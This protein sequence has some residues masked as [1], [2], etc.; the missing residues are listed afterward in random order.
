M[1]I[2]KNIFKKKECVVEKKDTF[3]EEYRKYMT[4]ISMMENKKTVYHKECL[5]IQ[6][7]FSCVLEKLFTNPI[8]LEN[9]VSKTTDVFISD[10]VLYIVTIVPGLY[11]GKGGKNID[12]LRILFNEFADVPINGIENIERISIIECGFYFSSINDNY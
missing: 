9:I 7:R 3:K 10:G 6:K 8:H 11:I 12:K 5:G 2:F 4:H 1:K